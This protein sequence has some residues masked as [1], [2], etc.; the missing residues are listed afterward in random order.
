MKAVNPK[1][2]IQISELIMASAFKSQ[3]LPLIACVNPHN[4]F[5]LCT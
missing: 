3:P 2:V 5:T 1:T 4:A